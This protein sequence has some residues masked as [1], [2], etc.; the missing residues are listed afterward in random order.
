M[1]GIDHVGITVSD[2]DRSLQFYRDLLGLTVLD[3]ATEGDPDLAAI[4]GLEAVEVSIADL[5]T[6]DGRI[7]ELLHAR[8]KEIA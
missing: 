5:A 6:G 3:R 8:L 1:P 2:L 4:V 7:L